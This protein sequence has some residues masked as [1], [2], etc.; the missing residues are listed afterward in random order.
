LIIVSDDGKGLDKN[1]IIEK[2]L[3]LNL[4]D[5]EK[6]QHLSENDIY[7]FIT[8]EGFSTKEEVNDISGR[9]VGVGA[10]YNVLKQ[11]GGTLEISSQKNKGTTFTLK[12]PLTLAI[13]K[14]LIV[15]VSD[16]TYI[17]PLS[18]IVETIDIKKEDIFTIMGKE[19]ICF[20]R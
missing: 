14:T 18:H 20:E 9:G 19:V 8:S 2:A 17:I 5:E 12:L 3:S 13:I 15:K 11:I 16:E 4:V 10:V 6:V 7:S 1:K